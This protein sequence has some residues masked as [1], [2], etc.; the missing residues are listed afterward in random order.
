MKYEDLE[1]LAVP[2]PED[3]MKEK[4]SGNFERARAVITDRLQGRLPHSLRCRLEFEL[5][6]LDNLERCY[7]LT[8][9]DALKQVREHIPGFTEEEFDELRKMGRIDWIYLEGEA[10]YL[11]SFCATL[12][13]VYPDLWKRTGEGDASDYSMLEGLIS[14]LSDGQEVSCHIHLRQELTLAPEAVEEG[15]KL[16]VHMPIPLE[17]HGVSNLEIVDITPAPK[18]IATEDAAQPTVYFEETARKGQVFS[19]EYSLDHT[20]KYRDMSKVDLK[21]VLTAELPEDT[22]RFLGECLPHIQFSPYIRALAGELAGGEANPLLKARAF[23]DFITAKTDY[24]F[25]RDYAC[26]ENL[27]EYCALNMKGDCGVQALLFIALCR[28]SGIPAKWE[29]GLDAKP[30]DAGEHDWAMFYVPSVGW[31][32]AD[33]SYGASSYT[34]G[35]YG[36][37][38]FYFGN[39][40]PYR[41]PINSDFQKDFSPP[42]KFRRLDPF[43]NQCGEAEYC[44]HGLYGTDI[45][46]KYHEIDFHM[47]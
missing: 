9:E 2:L 8:K 43:D 21:K 11:D 47:V 44:D 4:W 23:Y 10:L 3:V 16:Y 38:N 20:V 14:G 5:M 29:S 42:K 7:T 22:M 33:L 40:D 17:R 36:R 45:V 32:Y 31:A 19:I 18:C 1:H 28:V 25:V 41:I 30:G 15:R 12:F 35:A 34:R 46:Y 24:R 13:K 39:I 37:W 6:N 27:A 26:I